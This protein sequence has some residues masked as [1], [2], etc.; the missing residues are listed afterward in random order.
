MSAQVIALPIGDVWMELIDRKRLVR[1]M[2]IRKV[3][4]RQ[5]ATAAGWKSHSYVGRLLRG[6]VK[7]LDADPALRIA[8]YLQSPV[9]DLFMTNVDS[10]AVHFGQRSGAA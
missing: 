5:L 9:D 6:E 4:Q 10:K 2:R 3:S 7:T 8:F 1:L